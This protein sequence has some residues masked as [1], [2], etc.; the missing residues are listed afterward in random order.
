MKNNYLFENIQEAD[1]LE[2]QSSLEKYNLEEELAGINFKDAASILD[3]GCGA[4]QVTRY[5]KQ[6]HSKSFVTGVDFSPIR[7]EQAIAKAEAEELD[8]TFKTE[9]L[10]SLLFPDNSFDIV[11]IRYVLEHI[12]K[13]LSLKVLQEANRVLKPSGKIIVIDFDGPLFNFF[14]TTYRIEK[15][16]QLF[17]DMEGFDLR[18][19]RKIPHYLTKSGFQNISWSIKTTEVKDQFL[20]DELKLI[21]DKLDMISGVVANHLGS[22]SEAQKFK[23]EY[24]ALLQQEGTVSFYNKFVVIASK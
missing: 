22:K 12:P 24:L 6:K 15:V 19:G 9:D 14:P 7:I 18:I 8:V 5:L 21:P 23:E 4:G 11:I 16:I 1:R 10:S 20:Q 17:E 13:A 2:F 3:A